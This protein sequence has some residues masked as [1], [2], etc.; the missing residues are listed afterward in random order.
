MVQFIDFGSMWSIIIE[1]ITAPML[2]EDDGESCSY[3][4]RTIVLFCLSTYFEWGQAVLQP[5]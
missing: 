2:N 4:P 1:T 3:Q 5:R